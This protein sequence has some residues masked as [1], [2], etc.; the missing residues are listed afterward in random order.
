M[1]LVVVLLVAMFLVVGLLVVV[2]LVVGLLV[3][4][5]LVVGLLVA[6]F[7]VVMLL[8]AVFLVV[9]LLVAVFLLPMLLLPM[10]LVPVIMADIKM[11]LHILIIQVIPSLEFF[12]LKNYLKDRLFTSRV[13]SAAE[14]TGLVTAMPRKASTR[15]SA[16][17]IMS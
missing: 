10:L 14:G 2:L 9:V 17:F 13:P 15:T 12:S 4:V 11:T 5:L 6:M 16:N 1:L 7:L 3:V 8:V